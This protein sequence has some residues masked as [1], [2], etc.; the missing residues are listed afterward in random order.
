MTSEVV[1]VKYTSSSLVVLVGLEGKWG[2]GVINGGKLFNHAT[3][4]KPCRYSCYRAL[5]S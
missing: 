2:K 5:A 4:L 3:F 1:V